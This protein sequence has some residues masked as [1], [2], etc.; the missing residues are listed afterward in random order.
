MK[1]FILIVIL[2]AS[3][4]TDVHAG[5]TIELT[6]IINIGTYK[7]ALIRF[8]SDASEPTRD[9]ILAEDQRENDLKL[10]K[11]NPKDRNVEVRLGDDPTVILR[12]SS[13]PEKTFP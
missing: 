13:P 9:Y 11:I 3:I 6:G 10:I 5:A 1:A 4:A 8:R 2:L 7:T 12:L